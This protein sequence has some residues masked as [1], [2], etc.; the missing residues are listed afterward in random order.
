[1]GLKALKMP[2]FVPVKSTAMKLPL[3]MGLLM[4]SG[5]LYAQTDTSAPAFQFEDIDKT[6][7]KRFATQKIPSAIPNRFISIGY[8]FQGA[9]EY[10]NPSLRINPN[11]V[12]LASAGGLRIA[13]NNPV[14]SKN[15]LIINLGATYWRTGYRADNPNT[16]DLTQQLGSYGMHSAGLNAT[17]FKPLNE[18]RFLLFQVTGDANLITDDFKKADMRAVTV[19]GTAIYGWKPNEDLM[20]GIGVAR[21][22]RMGRVLHIPVLMYNRNFNE[23]WGVEAIFPARVQFRRNFSPKSMIHMGYELEGN[24]Y[25]KYSGTHTHFVQRGEI[26]PRITWE[27]SLSGFWWISLQA[28]LRANGRFVEVSKYDG[29]EKDELYKPSFGNT[30]FFNVSLN[31]V[32]L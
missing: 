1:M 15:N 18:K 22:Y 20:W 7:V 27:R 17:I 6:P 5:L 14:I 23:R 11:T 24:Q 32:S 28:G 26:K 31:L 3:T 25:A 2:Q 4:L 29:K 13:V 16:L 21:T 19:S 10:S 12:N 30:F 8:E 9:A